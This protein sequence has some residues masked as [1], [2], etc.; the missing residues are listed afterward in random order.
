MARFVLDST[1]DE[2]L[3]KLFSTNPDGTVRLGWSATTQVPT[4]VRSVLIEPVP[5]RDYLMEGFVSYTLQLSHHPLGAKLVA[6]GTGSSRDKYVV[7]QVRHFVTAAG[8]RVLQ[9]SA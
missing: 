5:F 1:P 2:A 8:I 3:V 6:I 9:E 4:D 7:N